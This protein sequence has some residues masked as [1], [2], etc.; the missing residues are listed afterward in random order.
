MRRA[1]KRGGGRRDEGK[2]T[3]AG[4]RPQAKDK[5]GE[6]KGRSAKHGKEVLGGQGGRVTPSKTTEK[7]VDR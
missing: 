4:Q 2:V 5:K 6:K 1:E 7:T 3:K